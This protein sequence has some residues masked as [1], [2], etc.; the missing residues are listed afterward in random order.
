[1][2]LSTE[3][4]YQLLQKYGSYIK[5][6]CDA[7]GRGIGPVR[8]TRRNDDGVWCSRICRDGEAASRNYDETRK[9]RSTCLHCKLPMPADAPAGSRYCDSACKK[10]RQRAKLQRAA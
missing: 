3:Q 1:M 10:A 2:Q 8:H 4:S 9:D 5:E 7:C 6:L